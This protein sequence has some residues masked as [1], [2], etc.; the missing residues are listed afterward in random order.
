MHNFTIHTWKREQGSNTNGTPQILLKR[1]WY[2]GMNGTPQI[3]LKKPLYKG[4]WDK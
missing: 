1:P 4:K 2:K 3:P